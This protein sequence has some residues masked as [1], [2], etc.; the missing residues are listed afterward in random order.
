MEYIIKPVGGTLDGCKTIRGEFNLCPSTSLLL[1]SAHGPQ[2]FS[3]AALNKFYTQFTNNDRTLFKFS[4]EVHLEVIQV[5]YYATALG[6][7]LNRISLT[8]YSIED[9][10]YV[11]RRPIPQEAILL[12]FTT[13]FNMSGHFDSLCFT[14]GANVKNLLVA[15]TFIEAELHIGEVNFFSSPVSDEI[16]RGEYTVFPTKG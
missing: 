8:F 4:S 6:E 15:T 9:D 3:Q 2:N 14:L 16:C 1:D 10:R 12:G 5:Y 7:G 11:P 13:K